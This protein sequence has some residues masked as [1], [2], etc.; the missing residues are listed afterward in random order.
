MGPGGSLVTDDVDICYKTGIFNERRLVN[1]LNTVSATLQNQA[2]SSGF[3]L[4]RAHLNQQDTTKLL[5]SYGPLGLMKVVPG[6]GSFEDVHA[7][8]DTLDVDGVSVALININKLIRA[9]ETAGRPKDQEAVKQLRAVR[10]MTE[11]QN[12]PS[13]LPAIKP[14]SQAKN[15]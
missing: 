14:K 7:F 12:M 5:T 4:T 2:P 15:N 3:V 10:T 8:S 13:G 1:F 11:Q 6:V 9:K